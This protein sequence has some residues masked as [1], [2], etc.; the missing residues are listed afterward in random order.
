MKRGIFK[1]ALYRDRNGNLHIERTAMY[2]S[3]KD[4]QA[5]LRGNGYRVLKIWSG[6]RT[7]RE[8]DEWEYLNRVR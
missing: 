7:D 3:Q 5:D 2:T 8:V 4:F 1:T 6:N